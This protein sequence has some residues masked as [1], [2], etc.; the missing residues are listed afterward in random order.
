MDLG[1]HE[2]GA[3]RVMKERLITLALSTLIIWPCITPVM[4]QG[5]TVG[6]TVYIG[7]F[8]Y[9]CGLDSVQVSLYDQTGSLVGVASSPYG[10]EVAISFRMSTP[11]YSLTARAFGHATLGSYYSWFVSGSR[12]IEVGTGGNYWISVAMR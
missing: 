1:C 4:A 11:I 9:S 2:T 3:V 5:I 6:Y 7:F 12:M 8:S 10:G